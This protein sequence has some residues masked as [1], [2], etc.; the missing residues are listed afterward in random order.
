MDRRNDK[1]KTESL[2][3]VFKR[4]TALILVFAL[5]F[6]SA[7]A[8]SVAIE[9]RNKNNKNIH[10]G[11]PA[12]DLGLKPADILSAGD[13]T[14]GTVLTE[15]E[16]VP[17]TYFADTVFLGDSITTGFM[18]Y[19]VFEDFIQVAKIGTN[20]ESVFTDEIE[21]DGVK[22]TMFDAIVDHY[23]PQKIYIMLGANGINTYPVDWLI[24]KYGILIDQLLTRLP[25]CS[26]VIQS[27]TPVTREREAKDPEHYSL[28]NI[29]D[30]NDKLKTMAL[31][32]GLYFLDVYS[33]VA[34]A[35]GYM[36]DA[37]A[38]SD[39]Y[40]MITEGYELWHRYIVTHTIR[41][42][43]AFAFTQEGLLKGASA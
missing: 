27:I 29:H 39:G 1:Q 40:H 30:F 11:T 22:Y 6:A 19:K 8:A 16:A 24:E 36:P 32:R 14:A 9:L 43:S 5:L 17:D 20:T 2:T 13:G 18:L 25:G 33:A 34:D 4:A 42:G 31:S 10:T 35:E 23:R 3:A 38:A 41:G 21:I 26:I 12:A 37:I 7:A 28:A 15:T